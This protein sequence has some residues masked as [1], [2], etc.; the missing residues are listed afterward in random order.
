M[1]DGKTGTFLAKE[2]KIQLFVLNKRKKANRD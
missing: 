1:I 2:D